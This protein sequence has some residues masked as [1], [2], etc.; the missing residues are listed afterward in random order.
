MDEILK[1]IIKEEMSE[2]VK[3]WGIEGTED[4]IKMLYKFNEDLKEEVLKILHET[5]NFGK[6]K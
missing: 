6:G 1:E 4:K 5:Y 2:W 3:K